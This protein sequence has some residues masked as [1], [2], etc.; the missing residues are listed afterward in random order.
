MIKSRLVSLLAVCSIVAT[1]MAADPT[2]KPEAAKKP[3]P[4]KTVVATYQYHSGCGHVGP[5]MKQFHTM[6]LKD[7]K[8]YHLVLEVKADTYEKQKATLDQVA[9]A[10]EWNNASS[11]A[12]TAKR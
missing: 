9:S 10:I 1:A 3:D 6:A 8:I 5:A 7:G 12:L 4:A 11:T 2:V